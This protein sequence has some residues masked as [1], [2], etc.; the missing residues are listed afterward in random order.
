MTAVT[1]VKQ[2]REELTERNR[3]TESELGEKP[4]Q[5]NCLTSLSVGDYQSTK[6]RNP[7]AHT[8]HQKLRKQNSDLEG[9]VY[10]GAAGPKVKMNQEIAIRTQAL[11]RLPGEHKLV[12]AYSKPVAKG[13]FVRKEVRKAS[14]FDS[15]PR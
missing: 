7:S 4:A 6:N 5:L 10:L 15:R 14:A 3:Q 8:A 11:K 12:K 13:N 9:L 1:R 2:I